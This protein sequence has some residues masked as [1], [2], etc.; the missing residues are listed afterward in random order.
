MDSKVDVFYQALFKVFIADDNELP[1]F[2]RFAREATSNATKLDV[3]IRSIADKHGINVLIAGELMNAKVHSGGDVLLLD[4]DLGDAKL[5]LPDSDDYDA[6]IKKHTNVSVALNV[7]TTSLHTAYQQ[8]LQGGA[9]EDDRAVVDFIGDQDVAFVDEEIIVEYDAFI[10]VPEVAARFDS[11]MTEVMVADLAGGTFTGSINVRMLVDLIEMEAKYIGALTPSEL[12]VE[13]RTSAIA[14]LIP[15]IRLGFNDNFQGFLEK[16]RGIIE[17]KLTTYIERWR[18]TMLEQFPYLRDMDSPGV[19]VTTLDEC[20]AY[21]DNHE[22]LTRL[23]GNTTIDNNV[24]LY[25]GDRVVVHAFLTGSAADAIEFDMSLY[26]QRLRSLANDDAVIVVFNVPYVD[27]D[28]KL[29]Q[30][31]KGKVKNVTQ[32]GFDIVLDGEG[33][34]SGFRK[35]GSLQRTLAY[36]HSM[37]SGYFVFRDEEDVMLK[38]K[39]ELLMTPHKVL[40]SDINDIAM[41]YPT[42][43]EAVMMEFADGDGNI[44]LEATSIMD[45]VDR[46]N[47]RFPLL[48]VDAN[49][50]RLL[51]GL[52]D[53]RVDAEIKSV[54]DHASEAF[55]RKAGAQADKDATTT[56]STTVT[57]PYSP[58]PPATMRSGRQ[59][60][61][62][63]NNARPAVMSVHAVG[64]HPFN[65]EGITVV[66]FGFLGVPFENGVAMEG[67]AYDPVSGRVVEWEEVARLRKDRMSALLNDIIQSRSN[68]VAVE[69]NDEVQEVVEMQDMMNKFVYSIEYDKQTKYRGD[70]SVSD[71]VNGVVTEDMIDTHGDQEV[72]DMSG[73]LRSEVSNFLTGLIGNDNRHL[74][75]NIDTVSTLVLTFGERN[76][77]ATLAKVQQGTVGTLDKPDEFWMSRDTY[78]LMMS[79]YEN[80]ESRVLQELQKIMFFYLP[81]VTKCLIALNELTIS[82][83]TI[84]EQGQLVDAAFEK[85]YMAGWEYPRKTLANKRISE[86]LKVLMQYDRMIKGM[87]NK[88]STYIKHLVAF[89]Q[90]LYGLQSWLTYR[91]YV[92]IDV[93][94]SVQSERVVH[95][96]ILHMHKVVQGLPLQNMTRGGTPVVLNS[97]IKDR[98]HDTYGYHDMMF[99]KDIVGAIKTFRASPTAVDVKVKNIA[100][101]PSK[102]FNG[103]APKVE[104]ISHGKREANP[105]SVGQP[106]KKGGIDEFISHNDWA[107]RD[108]M[109]RISAIEDK[110]LG[111]LLEAA[112]LDDASTKLLIE[113]EQRSL[114]IALLSVLGSQINMI[115]KDTNVENY[116]N[117]LRTDLLEDLSTSESVTM[118]SYMLLQQL[119]KHGGNVD[120]KHRVLVVLSEMVRRIAFDAAMLDNTFEKMREE[121]NQAQYGA[122][123]TLGK[124]DRE[125]YVDLM[126]AKL[127]D[128]FVAEERVAEEEEETEMIPVNREG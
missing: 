116:V 25:K 31:A 46:L 17:N 115:A 80:N 38:S 100:L 54:K 60:A 37:Y 87:T 6:L 5:V 61:Q 124:E 118:A 35:S 29:A 10:S 4:K 23:V 43:L 19:R 102:A 21:Y 52:I 26:R 109:K 41:L 95:K 99:D 53:M 98:V 12:F 128:K 18:I 72:I 45:A 73:S 14:P 83:V 1:T 28:G 64:L 56:K 33:V 111:R 70:P 106:F 125:I 48:T 71:D 7:V 122:L 113:T 65:K 57:G 123:K 22:R 50:V 36:N 27:V 59:E 94:R 119:S 55:K 77:R 117:V 81:A 82:S 34:A 44:A 2:L 92:N 30:Q 75:M 104:V 13:G 8:W 32:T 40:V 9:S 68:G 49:D 74:S 11:K 107:F 79:V 105:V 69:N 24:V 76:L 58:P 51:R 110:G 85:K 120:F 3:A 15:C 84:K 114:R 121:Y 16:W 47:L 67:K 20:P 90:D 101:P 112:D 89:P 62:Q 91:P 96:Y 66:D 88:S 93:A 39:R 97:V 108:D 86:T 78:N 103:A 127:V 63:A 42:A 126:N